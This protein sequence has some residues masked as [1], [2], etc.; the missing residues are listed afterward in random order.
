MGI[1][2]AGGPLRNLFFQRQQTLFDPLA[3]LHHEANFC[4]Q[5]SHIGAG[6]VQQALCL[7]D[8]VARGIVGLA[9]G[10]EVGLDM[11][12]IGHARF[13]RIDG[14]Q[15]FGLHLGLVGMRF[16]PLQKPLLVLLEGDLGLQG[17]VFLRDFGLLFQ[18]FQVV[19]EL[20]QNIFYAG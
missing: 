17:F 10:F 4:L 1:V 12:Q 5:A 15:R 13:E 18:L 8:L 16:G 20:S 3:A 7:V 9:H 6:F 2:L 11:A 19:G 14:A